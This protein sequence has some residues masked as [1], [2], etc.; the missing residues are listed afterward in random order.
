MEFT[1]IDDGY[2]RKD[3]IGVDDFFSVK[4]ENIHNLTIL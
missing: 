2:L 4:I 3:K 1:V